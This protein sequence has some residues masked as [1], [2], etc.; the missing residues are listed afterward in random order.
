MVARNQ[1][2]G[3]AR[4]IEPVEAVEE[5]QEVAIGGMRRV[6]GIARQHDE[7]DLVL[8]RRVDNPVVRLHNH[9]LQPLR[10]SVRKVAEP[11]HRRP[12]M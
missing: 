5:V 10:P 7:I 4:S 12:N 8:N 9:A 1:V 3:Y 6:E 2:G 11:P